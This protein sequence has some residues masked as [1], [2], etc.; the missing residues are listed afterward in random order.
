M[1]KRER[2]PLWQLICLLIATTGR[3]DLLAFQLR[4]FVA[5]LKRSHKPVKPGS[6]AGTIGSAIA[7]AI[8]LIFPW[9]LELVFG[10]AFSTFFIGLFVITPAVHWLFAKYGKCR[11]HDGTWTWFDYNQINWDE[12]HGMFVSVLPSFLFLK[13]LRPEY[14]MSETLWFDLVVAFI[15]FRLFDAKKP[16]LIKEIEKKFEDTDLGVMID[17]TAAG[18][19]AAICSNLFILVTLPLRIWFF[20]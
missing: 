16:G 9:T 19:A 5:W 7:L 17:D 8:L 4:K 18:V 20:N 2:T 14:H 3:S 13:Y 11:R 1:V 12:V 6:W 15:L 10:L